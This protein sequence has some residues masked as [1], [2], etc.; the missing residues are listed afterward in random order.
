M[1]IDDF[2][3]AAC[4]QMDIKFGT[5]DAEFTAKLGFDLFEN[6]KGKLAARGIVNKALVQ[7]SFT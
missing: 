1:Q 4:V 3:P 2:F 5:M 6:K 7:F